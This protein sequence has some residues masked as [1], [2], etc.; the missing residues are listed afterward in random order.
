MALNPARVA[1]A[2]TGD[3]TDNERLV[4]DEIERRRDDLVA[5]ARDLIGFDTTAREQTDDPARDE[6]ACQRYLAVRLRASGAE[7]DV[8]EPAAEDIATSPL[9]PPG[10]SFEGRP[11]LAARFPG[12]GGGRS[13]L[14]NGHID[15]VT[16]EPRER[17]TSD[18]FKA[19]VRDGKLYGRGACDMKGGIAAMVFAAETLADLGLRLAGDLVVCTVTDEESTGAGG[20][21]AVAHGVRAEAGITTESSNGTVQIACR[22]SLIPTITVRGRPGHSGMPQPHW[23]EDGAVNAIEKA[24]VVADALRRFEAD[25]RQRESNRHPYLAPGDVVLAQIAGGEWAVSYPSSCRLVYH[26][27][28]LPAHADAGGWGTAVEAEIVEWIAR[29]A[30]ADPWLAEH[31]PTIEWAPQVPAVEVP[32]DLPIVPILLAASAAVGRPGQLGGSD[33]WNDAATFTQGGTPSISFFPSDGKSAHATDEY[34]RV[35]DLVVGA[36]ILAL[37]AIRFCGTA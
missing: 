35:E 20:V 14:F 36:Q 4:V 28:Y 31:P 15:V 6:A 5:L 7:T 19:E 33:N 2:D 8:W 3:M 21:A 24:I 26:V 16:A 11:Q 12:A 32:P 18:P 29:T 1:G 22:G 30:R 9:I 34:T 25:W 23:R 13:L 27:A 10:L 17:W 37:A